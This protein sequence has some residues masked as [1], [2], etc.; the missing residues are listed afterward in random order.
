VD[1]RGVWRAGAGRSQVDKPG[2]AR[3]PDGRNLRRP[4]EDLEAVA[5]DL[6]FPVHR[7]PERQADTVIHALGLCLALVACPLLLVAAWP[8]ARPL[9]LAALGV[10][11]T[12]LVAMLGCSALYNL[13]PAGVRKAWFR[14]LDHAAIFAMIAGTYTPFA[15]V[16]IGGRWGM[17]LLVFVWV[18]ACAGMAVELLGLRRSDAL[19]TG[20]Y[21]LLGW[22]VLLALEPLVAAMSP[23]GLRL[24]VAG[25]V[26]YTVGSMFH[27]WPS[28]PYHN[29]IWHGF[30]LA[31]AAC[32]YLAVLVDVAL[33]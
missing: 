7:R 25:G 6:S 23:P 1:C 4:P 3:Y 27:H 31:A 2:A 18:V 13:T 8:N 12:G 17:G 11:A 26:L 29:A 30:V 20:A 24:L 14:R 21:L 15:L 32:H 16:T 9:R 28:L 10:Y 33:A 22:V 19:L 5:M